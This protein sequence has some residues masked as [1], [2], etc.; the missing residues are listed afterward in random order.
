MVLY[1]VTMHPH[2]GILYYPW[3]YFTALRRLLGELRRT[4][5]GNFHI[6]WIMCATVV[7]WLVETI[8]ERYPFV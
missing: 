6:S 4:V 1:F 5:S 2:M 7:V 3:Q 8:W